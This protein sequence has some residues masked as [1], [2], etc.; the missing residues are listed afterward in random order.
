[1][2]FARLTV[3]RY[4]FVLFDILGVIFPGSS[5][6]AIYPWPYKIVSTTFLPD[7]EYIYK[8]RG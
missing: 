6:R 7:R 3:T 2:S 4:E 8:P 1:M 5:N